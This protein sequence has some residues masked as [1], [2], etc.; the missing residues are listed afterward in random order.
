MFYMKINLFSLSM[1]FLSF[2]LRPVF[3]AEMGEYASRF[4]DCIR[5]GKIKGNLR[6]RNEYVNSSIRPKDANALTFSGKLGYDIVCGEQEDLHVFVEMQWNAAATGGFN[7]TF[8]G[9]REY[10]VVADPNAAQLNN[11]YLEYQMFDWLKI[12]GG[13][14]EKN[15]G[16]QSLVGSVGWRNL[17]TSFDGVE[18]LITPDFMADTS[19]ELGYMG[20]WTNVRNE[21][22]RMNTILARIAYAGFDNSELS[23]HLILLDFEEQNFV[24]RSTA[25]YGVAYWVDRPVLDTDLGM[26]KGRLD[27]AA[28]G[29]N[30]YQDNPDN[31][32]VFRTLVRG[33]VSINKISFY[34]GNELLSS[35]G[36]GHAFQRDLST[37]HAVNGWA[38]QFLRTPRQGLND[39]EVGMIFKQVLGGKFKISGHFYNS[40]KEGKH[41]GNE[42]DAAY[43]Y[44]LDKLFPIMPD[45]SKFLVKVAHFFGDESALGGEARSVTKVWAQAEFPINY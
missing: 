25:T 17:G 24:H 13:R 43:S 8:N 28:D 45:G 11:A 9:K 1:I 19:I 7:D 2:L 42:I 5:G 21:E 12:K 23:S 14:F 40:M 44:S 22:I 35:D 16:D 37:L 41:Y 29:Q 15:W 6:V 27:L 30:G 36:A 39:T 4:T 34:V 38:D 10:P 3:A 20:N 33:T 31:Y 26:I 32:T 18:V